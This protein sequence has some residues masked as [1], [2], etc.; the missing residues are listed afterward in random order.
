MGGIPIS[1]QGGKD[2]IIPGKDVVCIDYPVIICVSEDTGIMLNDFNPLRFRAKDNTWLS[3]EK[4]LFLDSATVS[5]YNSS[6]LFQS[7]NV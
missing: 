4:S 3:K 1:E 6:I 2:D 5:H 7:Q